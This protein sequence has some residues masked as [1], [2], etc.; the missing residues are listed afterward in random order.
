MAQ[1]Y[2]TRLAQSHTSFRAYLSSIKLLILL[3]QYSCFYYLT[4]YSNHLL[5][6]SNPLY[7]KDPIYSCRNLQQAQSTMPEIPRQPVMPPAQ[8]DQ[9]LI[10]NLKDLQP[11]TQ[12]QAQQHQVSI[13]LSQKTHPLTLNLW[14]LYAGNQLPKGVPAVGNTMG[15][16]LRLRYAQTINPQTRMHTARQP[17]HQNWSKH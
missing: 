11:T 15:A 17:Q 6:R 5:H 1:L 8:Q 13:A 10:H 3:L 12:H 16:D 4:Q 14:S 2:T 7:S 9:K